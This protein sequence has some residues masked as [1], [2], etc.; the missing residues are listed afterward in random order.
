MRAVDPADLLLRGRIPQT[1]SVVST[2][3]DELLA[4]RQECQ[5][6]HTALMALE[7]AD[8]L[9]AGHFPK[10]DDA[11]VVARSQRSAVGAESGRH[12]DAFV[13]GEL[14]ELLSRGGLPQ[15]EHPQAQLLIPAARRS[16]Q[17]AVW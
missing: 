14:A 2:G 3:R 17:L 4:V 5:A 12:D 15:A 11:I 13:T 10:A 7:L 8:F 9:L 6:K 16:Q 1:G